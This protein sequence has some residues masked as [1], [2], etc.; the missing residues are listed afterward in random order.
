MVC[1][2]FVVIVGIVLPGILLSRIGQEVISG[3]GLIHRAAD[4]GELER[5]LRAH[6]ALGHIFRLWNDR[7]KFDSALGQVGASVAAL[8][9]RAFSNSVGVVVQIS[10]AVFATSFS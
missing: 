4:S 3:I 2:I 10:V 1:V 5:M 8:V 6:P 7:L 9:S